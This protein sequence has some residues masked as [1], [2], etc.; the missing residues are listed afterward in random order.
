MKANI[1][2]GNIVPSQQY[3][4]NSELQ[5]Q[6]VA[7]PVEVRIDSVSEAEDDVPFGADAENELDPGRKQNDKMISRK[8]SSE[9]AEIVDEDEY[10]DQEDIRA[11]E[12][13]KRS[14]TPPEKRQRLGKHEIETVRRTSV[15]PMAPPRSESESPSETAKD[16]HVVTEWE[17]LGGLDD[18]G[19]Y[20]MDDSLVGEEV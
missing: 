17:E 18:A 12:R 8:R 4:Q 14:K 20:V 15:S 11:E 16:I 19:L 1:E 5:K 3:V 9:A 13:N 10:G 7:P 2:A 6:T